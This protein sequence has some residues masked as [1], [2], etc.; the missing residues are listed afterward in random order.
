MACHEHSCEDDKLCKFDSD[1]ETGACVAKSEMAESLH[2]LGNTAQVAISQSAEFF[3]LNRM[4][5]QSFTNVPVAP[6]V[7]GS[8]IMARAFTGVSANPAYVKPDKCCVNLPYHSSNQGCCGGKLFDL[9]EE[10]C[11][12]GGWISTHSSGCQ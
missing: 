4:G 12:T 10:I 6:P 8:D 9:W 2:C 11:C 7:A 1:T 5:S 3:Q